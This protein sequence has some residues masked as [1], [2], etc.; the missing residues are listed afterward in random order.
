MADNAS[1]LIGETVIPIDAG[2][3]DVDVDPPLT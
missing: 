2:S 3:D 1:A